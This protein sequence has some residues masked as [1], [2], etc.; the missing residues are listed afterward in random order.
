MNA[1]TASYSSAPPWLT[2]VLRSAA[3]DIKHNA[4]VWTTLYAPVNA[5]KNHLQRLNQSLS[6]LAGVTPT[7]NKS[8]QCLNEENSC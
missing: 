6:Q 8:K 4:A 5:V 3:C 1:S 7:D 2:R